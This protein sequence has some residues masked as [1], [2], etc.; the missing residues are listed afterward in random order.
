MGMEVKLATVVVPAED[1]DRDFIKFWIGEVRSDAS[2]HTECD[3]DMT[4]DEEVVVNDS[5]GL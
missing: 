2:T 1:D 3:N 4:A 5:A